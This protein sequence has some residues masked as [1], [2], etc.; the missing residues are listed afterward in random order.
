MN[1]FKGTKT[2]NLLLLYTLLLVALR[3]THYVM[4]QIYKVYMQTQ[5]YNNSVLPSV[6]R[7]WNE[8]HE[9][10]RNSP[11]LNVFKKKKCQYNYATSLL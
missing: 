2:N 10:T 5:L 7:D 6:V 9:Q 8:L 11:S 3:H 1:I 4:L